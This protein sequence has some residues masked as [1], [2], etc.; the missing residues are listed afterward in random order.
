M[1]IFRYSFMPCIHTLRGLAAHVGKNKL[2]TFAFTHMPKETTKD[3]SVIRPFLQQRDFLRQVVIEASHS[4][5]TYI[6]VLT[7]DN[8]ERRAK[9]MYYDRDHAAQYTLYLWCPDHADPYY[10]TLDSTDA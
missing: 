10:H 6:Y 2:W 1:T 8:C 7:C 9:Y 3:Y 5:Q 4:H